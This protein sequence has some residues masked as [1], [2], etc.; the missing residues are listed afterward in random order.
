MVEV[1]EF[2]FE[3]W[4]HFVGTI[5]LILCTCLGLSWIASAFVPDTPKLRISQEGLE[6]LLKQSD[7]K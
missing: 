7:K 2:I 4:I 6:T 5:I 1:L 3:S